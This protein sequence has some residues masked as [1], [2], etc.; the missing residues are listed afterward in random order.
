M[1]VEFVLDF[2]LIAES[3]VLAPIFAESLGLEALAGSA[4]RDA[5]LSRTKGK[6]GPEKRDVFLAA[7]KPTHVEFINPDDARTSQPCRKVI[8]GVHI[9]KIGDPD[10]KVPP[11]HYNCRSSL[12]FIKP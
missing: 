8:D 4:L 2:A 12:A 5:I 6:T 11:L 3:Q 10:I 1:G 7:T 9:W